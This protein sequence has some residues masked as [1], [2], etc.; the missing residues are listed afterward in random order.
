MT[1]QY[2]LFATFTLIWIT[3][4]YFLFNRKNFASKTN[5]EQKLQH[6]IIAQPKESKIRVIFDQGDSA[7]MDIKTLADL[8]VKYSELLSGNY[9]L[10]VK[11]KETLTEKSDESEKKE[12]EKET[13]K[14]MS[15]Y[16]NIFSIK[17]LKNQ[18]K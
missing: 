5:R 6:D 15:E 4:I 9:N 12:I 7:D 17:K 18:S 16:I 3:G 10:P 1:I 8:T 13:D 11:E 14:D 2:L